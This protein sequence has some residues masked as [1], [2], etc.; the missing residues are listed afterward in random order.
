VRESVRAGPIALKVL[1]L[2]HRLLIIILL[3]PERCNSCCASAAAVDVAG[4]E[5]AACAD[6]HAPE[7][8]PRKGRSKVSNGRVL[9]AGVDQ[10]SPWVRR[11]RDVLRE[12]VADL[13]GV[14]NCSAAERS[15]IRRAAVLTT[16]LEQLETKFALAG[17]ADAGDLETYQRCSNTLR[18]LL[19]SVGLQR[20][21]RD[22]TTP[23]LADI[24]RE[25]EDE[26]HSAE[27]KA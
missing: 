2:L 16:E 11:C 5:I 9:I 25:I 6:P 21:A 24:A 15:I 20:R 19:E 22:V 10:R 1:L 4:T 23:S 8:A 14:D 12:H 17:Q 7:A 26:K 13:G 27:D 18:R 3:Q